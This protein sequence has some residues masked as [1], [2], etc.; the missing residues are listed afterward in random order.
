MVKKLGR[1]R[2]FA[3]TATKSQEKNLIENAKKVKNSPFLFL[4]EC[5]D[6]SS[7]KY[8]N[9]IKKKVEKVSKFKDE[10]E[11]LEKI[12]NKKGFEGAY[13]GTIL[14][15]SSEKAPYLG[16]LK[17]STGDITYAQR[18]KAQNDKLI[19]I[20]HYDD[21]IIR[22]IGFKDLS[23]KKKVFFYSWNDGFTCTGKVP[24]PPEA[25]K[26]FIINKF[27]LPTKKN[28]TYCSHLD[29]NKVKNSE[30]DK[31]YYLRI[32]WKSAN[33][34]FAICNDCA[35]N[36]KNTLFEISK[37][38]L[39]PNLSNDFEIS[40]IAQVIKQKDDVEELKTQYLDD[41]LS[42]K[43][44]DL[45]FISKNVKEIEEN[46]KDS[47]QKILVLDGVSYGSNVEKFVSEL[48]PNKYEKD[49]LEFILQ[50]IEE[51][52]V[53][54]DASPNKVLEIHWKN[55]GKEYINSVID[56]KDMIDSFYQLDD[57]PSNIVKMIFEYKERQKIL[58]Q[59]PRY[60]KLPPLARFA[61]HISR[62]YKTFGEKKTIIEI[63]KRP[64]NPKAK[65]IAYAFLLTLEKAQDTKWK[66]SK[67]EIE[68]GE[69]LK[70]YARKL[71]DSNPK[72]YNKNLQDLLVASGSNEKI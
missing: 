28:V 47:D 5:L 58:S 43:I 6:S 7:K 29:F 66:Y 59:L 30:F 57:T 55:Y 33:H 48:K 9:K 14:L 50:R 44:T 16:V 62:T 15:A 2:T 34:I 37:Y 25:F 21:P 72:N 18:G 63:K 24:N 20:Q 1:V 23:Y 40:V 12:S 3:R 45:E 19:S 36:T 56:D 53:L 49:A 42:G 41:Y 22:L 64:D 8:I 27:K 35:K 10:K 11:K 70:E 38:M 69:F 54:S 39:M 68:Y 46:I 71:L 4:P 52:L 65:S 51:P 31:E 67:E 60:E 13:A 26:K 61:D 17:Y 32:F